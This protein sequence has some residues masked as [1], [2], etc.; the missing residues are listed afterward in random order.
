MVEKDT[1]VKEK[2]K[3]A[4]LTDFEQAYKFAYAWF[5]KEEFNLTEDGYTE[6]AKSNGKEI[7]RT[8]SKKLSDYFKATIKTKWRILGMTDVEVEVDGRKKKMNKVVEIG[9][10]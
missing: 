8:A 7:E 6:K 9:M 3:Y 2:L 5:Q 1:V 10:E 4:G